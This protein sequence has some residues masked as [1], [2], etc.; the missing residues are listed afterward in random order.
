MDYG[1]RNGK[2]VKGVGFAGRIVFA[3]GE[4]LK[5]SLYQVRFGPSILLVQGADGRGLFRGGL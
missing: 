5:M 2:E 4:E 3:E 1:L